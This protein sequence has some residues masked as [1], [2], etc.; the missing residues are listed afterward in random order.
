MDPRRWRRFPPSWRYPL[1]GATNNVAAV[2]AEKFDPMIRG[3]HRQNRR[4]T[5]PGA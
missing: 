1:A 3:V 2:K 5:R 4:S